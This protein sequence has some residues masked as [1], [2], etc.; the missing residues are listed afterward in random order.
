M[1][2]A[3][4]L[5]ASQDYVKKTQTGFYLAAGPGQGGGDR[6]TQHFNIPVKL[7]KLL[8]ISLY[9]LLSQ[10]LYRHIKLYLLKRTIQI[11]NSI[12]EILYS[13]Q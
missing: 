7:H 11:L 9:K 13:K 8:Q 3:R 12:T 1:L 10:Y 5:N 4:G 6:M 2:D